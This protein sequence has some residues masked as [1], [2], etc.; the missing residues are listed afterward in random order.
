MAATDATRPPKDFA[1]LYTDLTNRIREQTGVAAT[2]NQAKRYINLALHD[3]H[4]GF[5]YK[6]PWAERRAIVRTQAPYTTGTVTIGKGDTTLVGSSTLWNTANDFSVN[7]VRVGGKITIAGTSDVYDVTAVA[8]DT[9]LTLGQAFIG[10]DVSAETYIYFEDEYALES[11]FL[12][13]VDMHQFSP[14]RNIGII[15]RTEFRRNF[16]SNDLRGT[17]V[18]ATI[19]DK[20]FSGNTT[21]V[22]KVKLHRAPDKEYL[23]PYDYITSN[24][25]VDA[26]GTAI[27]VMSSDTDE[28]IVPYNCRSAITYFALYTWY[29][30]KKD[31][32]QR[33]MDAKSQYI[34]VMTRIVSDQ[35][36][37]AVRPQIRPRVS[38]YVRRARRPY[39]GGSRR[40]DTDGSF[41]QMR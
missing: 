13:F 7:N 22:R 35:E 41:D 19:I 40:Y 33:A 29:R 5:E 18:V 37:G 8:S 38:P 26:S 14:E 31:D 32:L 1:D 16:P 39:T 9:S 11:D 25:A 34:D 6:M 30:D 20:P 15:S 10:S 28:P 4:L 23:L 24:L 17:P 36:V 3:M 2:Q 12:R 27:A 21:P